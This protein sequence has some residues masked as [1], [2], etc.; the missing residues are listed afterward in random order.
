MSLATTTKRRP[1]G[2]SG[3]RALISQPTMPQ[4][5]HQLVELEA[6]ADGRLLLGQGRVLLHGLGPAV[7][8]GLAEQLGEVVDV[9]GAHQV[10]LVALGLQPVLGRVGGGDG[11]QVHGA[12]LG[13][14]ADG[15]EDPVALL[16]LALGVD[17]DLDDVARGV[18]DDDAQRVGHAGAGL[19]ADDA[20]LHL[21]HAQP[22]GAQAEAV[23]EPLQR[24]LHLLGP[25]LEHGREVEEQVVEVRV[26][27]A[28]DL[29]R[30]ED[31]VDHPVR[32]RDQVLGRGDLVAQ[33]ARADHR[34]REVALVRLHP[35]A[36]GL[37]HVDVLVLGED[38]LD[39]EL[40]QPAQ[41]QLERQRRLDVADAVVLGVLGPAE[42]AARD[43]PAARRGTARRAAR[44][45]AA[46]RGRR[47]S[48]RRGWRR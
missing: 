30:V 15:V 28:D 23:Q 19:G 8:D 16:V 38:G 37:V 39:L 36:H 13:G 18:G 47:G 34:A 11:H 29:Q 24:L 40:A 5:L 14:A 2:Y 42:R 32:L 35:L 10:G 22:P 3:V 9:L 26:V 33:A 45:P 46:S 7:L 27:V 43:A 41:L 6:L 21:G 31:V 44:S 25:Q 12:D 4:V 17:L 20:D 48:R 1:R